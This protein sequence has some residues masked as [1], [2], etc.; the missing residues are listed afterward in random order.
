M[1]TLADTIKKYNID[2]NLVLQK[3]MTDNVF[4]ERYQSGIREIYSAIGNINRRSG[5][6]GITGQIV[7]I[8]QEE[9]QKYAEMYAL[10]NMGLAGG[11]APLDSSWFNQFIKPFDAS[12]GSAPENLL[13]SL[14]EKSA[15]IPTVAPK[16]PDAISSIQTVF[17]PDWKPAPIFEQKGLTGQGIYG[18]V[19]I[20]GMNDVYTL[21]PGGTKETAESYLAK[22]GSAD[23]KGIVGEITPEQAGR[24]GIKLEAPKVTDIKQ[25]IDL[26][27][28]KGVGETPTITLPEQQSQKIMESFTNSI[29]ENLDK[30]K[31]NLESRI[32]KER[33]SLATQKAELDKQIAGFTKQQEGVVGEVEKLT[34]P[35][36]EELEKTERARLQLEENYFK[37]Q[38][39]TDELDTL[40][41]SLK[42]EVESAKN[43]TGLASI[44]NP[45]IAK[46]QEDVAGRVGVIEAVMS[47]R[48]NQI[49]TAYTLIDRSINAIVSDRQDRLNYYKT[50]DSFISEQKGDAKTSLANINSKDKAFLT[51]QIS[52]L[53]NEMTQAQSTAEFI[54]DLMTDPKTADLAAQA[55]LSLNDS[56]QT[57]NKKLSTYAYKQEI[58]NTGNKMEEKGYVYLPL[59]SQWSTKPA[60]ELVRIKDSRGVERIYWNSEKKELTATE[61]ESN[62]LIDIANKLNASKGSD[63]FVDPQVYAEQ[64]KLS[65]IG[66]DEFDKRFGRSL[67]PTEQSKMVGLTKGGENFLTDEYVKNLFSAYTA[68]DMLEAMGKE[69][70]DY[71]SFWSWDS[72]EELDQKIKDDYIKTQIDRVKNFRS[73]GM[74]DEEI[75]KQLI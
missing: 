42:S 33:A 59:D 53:E 72:D 55:G 23:Q 52:M 28:I 75:L 39:L 26:G 37:N 1:A 24:L 15:G 9:Q 43:V 5:N 13:P 73:G 11:L 25:P 64:K 51:S 14:Y 7:G 47:A 22:F 68:D 21:G 6:A 66:P 12:G 54:K 60:E 2:P 35:F 34:A 58:I 74:S 36:R 18:A 67:S 27:E 61:K 50:L 30:T 56:A 29:A 62:T 57:I 4:Q 16:V 63:G 41:T 40:L 20:K 48:N 46:I 65:T 49:N 17:G 3:G 70:K 31:S 44:R 10:Q 45:R 19:R 32:A 38:Q 69:R 71:K 8:P